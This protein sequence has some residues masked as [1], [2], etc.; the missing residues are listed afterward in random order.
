MRVLVYCIG[1]S[2][3]VWELL[4]WQE[5]PCLCGRF[6]ILCI[7]FHNYSHTEPVKSGPQY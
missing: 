1:S 6:I 5:N 7:H 4:N 3:T 2:V